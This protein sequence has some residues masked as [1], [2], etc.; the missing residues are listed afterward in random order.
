MTY[1]NHEHRERENVRFL[2][3]PPPLQDFWRGPSREAAILRDDLHGIHVSKDGS[4]AEIGDACMARVVHKDVLLTECYCGGER[5]FRT[6]Y[7]FQISVKHVARV[8]ILE[9]RSNVRKLVTRVK[10]G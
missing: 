2:G 10:A 4:E 8:E 1:F 3:G 5:R 9:A 7:P 6:T